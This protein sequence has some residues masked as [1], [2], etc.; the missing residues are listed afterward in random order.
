MQQIT[1]PEQ[2][3][4]YLRV[5]NPGVWALLITVILLL[6]G[7]IAWSVSGTIETTVDAKAVVN[8]NMARIITLDDP[9]VELEAGMQFRVGSKEEGI[10]SSLDMDEYGRTIATGQVSLPD[11][12]Y[13]AEI[14]TE[15]IHPIQFLLGGI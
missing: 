8:N 9:G 11:G 13:D 4:D 14:V 10:I 1:S 6:M 5:T 15:L 3:S 12:R 7:V 2:L